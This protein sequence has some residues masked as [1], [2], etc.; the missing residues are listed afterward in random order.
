MTIRTNLF[1]QSRL[2][3]LSIIVVLF[4]VYALFPTQNPTSDAYDYAACVR[5]QV[6][7]WQPHHLLYN[8]TGLGIYTL[9]KEFKM[10]VP[11]LEVMQFLNSVFAGASLLV[12]WRILAQLQKEGKVQA[13]LLLLAGASLGTMR[14]ATE[15]ETYI[16]PLFCSLLGSYFWLRFHLNG[17]KTDVL[18]G[19]FW[20]AFAC[21]YHQVHFFWWLGLSLSFLLSPQQNGKQLLWFLL[22]A[23]VVPLGYAIVLYLQHIPFSQAHRFVFLDF[24]KGEVETT[25]TS[26]HFLLTGISFLRTFLEV[27]GRLYFLVKQH[28]LYII[29]AIITFTVLFIPC[30]NLL[31]NWKNTFLQHKAVFRTF[32]FILVLQV[33]FAW[34]A[35]GNAEFM[36]MVPVLTA[37]LAGCFTYRSSQYLFL[38]GAGLFVWNTVY[39]VLPN[40]FSTYTN[41]ACVLR[42]VQQQ[43]TAVLLLQDKNAFD[44]YLFYHTGQYHSNAYEI[45]AKPQ[46]LTKAITQ[47]QT[48]Q[49]P[50]VTDFSTGA[51]VLNRAWFLNDSSPSQFFR[52][53]QLQ[54]I[55]SCPTFYGEKE[56]KSISV[57][58]GAH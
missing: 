1:L 32:A 39:A 55:T 33:L 17:Q 19:G 2:L 42:L 50:I 35:V 11:P 4:L 49:Q 31:L 44:A 56:L 52:Q 6:D 21:L 41:H 57:L 37:I 36:V 24:Y 9:L 23:L 46:V 22:P 29:P 28:I 14:Y 5:W 18:W 15:N 34:Y 10:H 38:A 48:R 51:A 53:F 45:T 43:P 47:A 25:I 26:R 27:H 54:P 40:Y 16:I 12:L 7:L 30:R 3:P 13:G 58:P 20:A 8:I